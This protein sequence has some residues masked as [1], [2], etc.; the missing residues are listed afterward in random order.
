MPLQEDDVG[1]LGRLF[2]DKYDQKLIGTNLTQF[3][4]DFDAPANCH[5]P[6]HSRLLIALGKKSYLDVL[7][8]EEGNEGYHIRMKGVPQQCILNYC[9][10]QRIGLIELYERL[11]AGNAV[12]FDLTDG[13]A[14]F[15]KTKNFDQITLQKFYRRVKF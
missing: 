8:D 13:S 1:K 15:R 4:S 5:G 9:K 10:K 2:K 7:T 3:H 12:K 14:C 11:Y 6:V